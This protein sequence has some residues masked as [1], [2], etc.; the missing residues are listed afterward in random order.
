[1]REAARLCKFSKLTFITN[2]MKL[3][4]VLG[5][6]VVKGYVLIDSFSEFETSYKGFIS[7]LVIST[8]DEGY[9]LDCSK[10]HD[11][12]YSFKDIL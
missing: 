11:W 1:M 12:L 5:L 3:K 2:E 10:Y 8:N 9:L 6:I 4:E 7:W